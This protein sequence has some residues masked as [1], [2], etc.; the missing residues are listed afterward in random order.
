[1]V[2]GDYARRCLSREFEDS[3]ADSSARCI[4]V[5]AA[6]DKLVEGRI[7]DGQPRLADV[8]PLSYSLDPA[9]IVLAYG[10]FGCR[11]SSRFAVAI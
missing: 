11:T 6:L 3:R 5:Q 2:E 1:M 10:R 9:V 8:R 7:L 4:T